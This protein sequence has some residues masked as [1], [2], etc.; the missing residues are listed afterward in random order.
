MNK[1]TFKQ[2][3]MEIDVGDLQL[4]KQHSDAANMSSQEAEG[5]DQFQKQMNT[6]PSTNDF[7]QL[8][9]GFYTVTEM[10]R[11]GIHLQQVKGDKSG[12]LPHGTKF[13]ITGKTKAGNPIFS[14][15]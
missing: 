15:T 2:F 12:I 10:S 8:K 5:K 11:K 13:K 6:S 1:P 9:D 3:L 14:V 4:A 7:I